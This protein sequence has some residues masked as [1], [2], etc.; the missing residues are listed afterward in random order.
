MQPAAAHQT[1]QYKH[2]TDGQQPLLPLD[3]TFA[4]GCFCPGRGRG[5]GVFRLGHDLDLRGPSLLALPFRGC[6]CDFGYVPWPTLC[7]LSGVGIPYARDCELEKR[8]V[9][10]DVAY[11]L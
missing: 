3:H 4:S 1:G 10:N 7:G 8:C 5:R 6:G 9:C 2:G 11:Q